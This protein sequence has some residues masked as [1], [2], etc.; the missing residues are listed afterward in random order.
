MMAHTYVSDLVHCVFSTKLRQDTIPFDMQTRLW[1]FLGG[2]ARKNGFKAIA[3]GG[4]RNHIHTLLS[5][6]A[7]MPIAK[8]MQLLK[9]GSSK[10]MKENGNGKFAWQE[11]YGAFS[12][13][14]SQQRA[15]VEYINE[16]ARHHTKRSFEDE[17]LAFLKKHSIEYDPKY[18]WG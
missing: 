8:A 6:P 1:S 17:F 16:Q 14:I 5:L 12:V 3:I 18:V 7:T 11:A 13:S 15:T 10:W 4:T 9:G 2:I